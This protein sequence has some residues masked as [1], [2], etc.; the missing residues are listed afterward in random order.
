MRRRDMPKGNGPER[1]VGLPVLAA[2]LLQAACARRL[3]ALDAQECLGGS[4]EDRPGRGAGEAVR[5]LPVAWQDGRSGSVVE[6]DI[7]GFFA[8]MAQD[9]RLKRLRW[10]LADRACL[11][12]IRQ[13][14]HA[15]LLE[16]DGRVIHPA[17]GTPQG[18]VVSP[19]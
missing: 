7:Q 5:D 13:W 10:R 12:L 9:W 6:A 18:G 1:P 2:T 14:L 15:G 4:S 16:T 19:V 17:T 3:K 8:H 11:G